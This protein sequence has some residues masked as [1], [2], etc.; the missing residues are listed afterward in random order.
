MLDTTVVQYTLEPSGQGSDSVGKTY[1]DQNMWRLCVPGAATNA[2]N[3]W[4]KPLN[5]NGTNQYYDGSDHLTT[6]WNDYF[7]RSYLMHLA[8]QIQPPGWAPGMMDSA[9]YPS[10]G[11]TL[12]DERDGLNW[13]ASG[14]NANTYSNYFYAIVWWNS[15]SQATLLSQVQDDLVN[16]GVPVQPEVD[17]AIMP[18]WPDTTKNVDLIKHTYI[19]NYHKSINH[20]VTIVG[21][22]K[23]T[24]NGDGTFGTYSYTDTCGNS[25][26]C[27][28]LHDAGINTVP[29]WRMWAA[30]TYIPVNIS[31]ASNA[32]D[33]GWI[34]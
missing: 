30:I 3:Y 22:N 26:T 8:W 31:T 29:M 2:L 18:N 25:T 7:H 16:S 20:A 1:Y 15:A 23:N 5:Y 17:A 33:G 11:V 32:G 21:Y 9:H 10:N 12:Y 4:G 34:W 13:E 19:Q 14:E 27:G 28:S 6:T 24:D